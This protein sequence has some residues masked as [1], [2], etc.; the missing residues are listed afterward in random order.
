VAEKITCAPKREKRSVF[1]AVK[2]R[3]VEALR[4]RQLAEQRDITAAELIRRAVERE[5][6]EA[7]L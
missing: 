5:C 6:D 1:M 4:I 3:P 7:G 2:L